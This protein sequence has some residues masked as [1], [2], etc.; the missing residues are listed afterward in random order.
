MK[1]IIIS[2][3]L[4]LF[5]CLALAQ[6][7][8]LPKKGNDI[9]GKVHSAVV[10]QGDDFSKIAQENDVGY[11]QLVEA[12]PGINPNK[13]SVGTVL[14]IPSEYVLPQ[15]RWKGIVVNLAELRLYYFPK[16]KKVVMTY[17]LGIGR[18]GWDTPLG[19]HK[20]MQKRKNPTWYAPKSIREWRKEQGV[21]I[22]K[23]IPPGPDNPLGKY[24]MRLSAWTFLIHGTNQPEGVGRRTSSGCL[25]MYP[26]DIKQLYGLTKVGTRVNIIDKP[27]KVGWEG[28][29]LYIESHL[30]LQEMQ[31]KTKGNYEEIVEAAV[32]KAVRHKK[33][34]VNWD[35]L[36]HIADEQQGLPQQ[37]GRLK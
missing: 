13:P 3:I 14:I 37:I 35:K 23:V 31:Q 2:A 33:A 10:H 11:Y 1:K 7:F 24:A 18:E 28:R 34:L 17:P 9:V 25:R 6:T 4:F 12:N 16:G 27:F 29:K 30:P 20:I 15:V 8:P 22:P 21:D 36:A 32:K 5:P 26:K 19:I